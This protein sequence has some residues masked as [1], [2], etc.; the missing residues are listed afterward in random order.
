MSKR[1]SAVIASTSGRR[2]ST[3]KTWLADY[4]HTGVGL[5][6]KRAVQHIRDLERRRTRAFRKDPYRLVP[7]DK[8]EGAW[9]V[10]RWRRTRRNPVPRMWGLVAADAIGNLRSAL[11][12]L[13]KDATN[14]KPGHPDHRTRVYFPLRTTDEIKRSMNGAKQAT[15]KQAYGILLASKVHKGG[16]NDLTPLNEAWDSDK[17]EVPVLVACAFEQATITI[18]D[19]TGFGLASRV[20][21]RQP[22]AVED[23]KVFMRVRQDL[24]LEDD[25]QFS[26]DVQFAKGTALEGQPVVACLSLFAGIAEMLA[27]TFYEVGLLK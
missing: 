10:Y 19:N 14:P 1:R 21:A 17:H 26:F 12:I 6:I 22:T 24:K 23:G 16:H 13:W 4:R 5:K 18:T 2:E 11:D 8:P 3:V 27:S 25:R 20:R 9:L 7:D 15:V